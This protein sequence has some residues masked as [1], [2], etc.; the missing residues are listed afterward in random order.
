MGK[1]SSQEKDSSS[2]DHNNGSGGSSSN[3]DVI[4]TSWMTKRSQLKSR[5]SFSNYKDRWFVLTRHALIYYDGADTLK[6]KEK[7]RINLKDVK[8]IEQVILRD[9]SKHN[10]FQIGYVENGQ[11]YSLYIQAKAESERDEWIQLIRNLCRHNPQLSDKYHPNQW[12][13]GKW[14]CCAEQIRFG[15]SGGCEQI[16][17]TPRMTKLDP[18]PPLPNAAITSNGELDN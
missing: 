13:A 1:I 14:L 11:E 5:F 8:L 6:K 17:W 2:H 15:G 7:G 12:S 9:D 18:V 16:T 4:K 3:Q 10:A